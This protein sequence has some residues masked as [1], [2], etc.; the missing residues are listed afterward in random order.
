MT[1]DWAAAVLDTQRLDR[2]NGLARLPALSSGAGESHVSRSLNTRQLCALLS[3]KG[4]SGT[5]ERG[6][7]HRPCGLRP[8]PAHGTGTV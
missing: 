6:L 3:G 1:L 2:G 8:V 5:A 7:A 4:A